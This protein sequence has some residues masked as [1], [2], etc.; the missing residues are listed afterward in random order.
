MEPSDSML[1]I[2][3]PHSL[4]IRLSYFQLKSAELAISFHVFVLF[5][6]SFHENLV[7]EV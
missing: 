5:T 2:V 3:G 6:S 7:Q 4:G 1:Y